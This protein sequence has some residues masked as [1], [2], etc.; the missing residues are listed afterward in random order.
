MENKDAAVIKAL[1]ELGLRKEAP[2]SP[3]QEKLLKNAL[4]PNEQFYDAIIRIFDVD[5]TTDP[6]TVG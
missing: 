4:D 6:P 5:L 2:L 3:E 1:S